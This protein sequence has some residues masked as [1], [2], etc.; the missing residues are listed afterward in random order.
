MHHASKKN[1]SFLSSDWSAWVLRQQNFI[2]KFYQGWFPY[3]KLYFNC[4]TWEILCFI[5]EQRFHKISGIFVY[6]PGM[7]SISSILSSLWK[8][9][10]QQVRHAHTTSF[11][12]FWLGQLA[13]EYEWDFDLIL[14]SSLF[15][16]LFTVV[17]LAVHT[18]SRTLWMV[19]SLGWP[20]FL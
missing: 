6:L 18:S 17:S 15:C 13:R 11:C 3:K 8:K 2:A 16:I 7:I 12:I 5:V 9:W 1:A 20:L 14:Y 10:G 19:V 4:E